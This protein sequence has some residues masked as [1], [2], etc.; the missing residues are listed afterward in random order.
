MELWVIFPGLMIR[1]ENKF[2]GRLLR[3]SNTYQNG[4][5]LKK[6]RHQKLKKN[7]NI[8]Q[9]TKFIKDK[10]CAAFHITFTFGFYEYPRNISIVLALYKYTKAILFVFQNNFLHKDII[11]MYNE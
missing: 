6:G 4:L 7:I 10:T 2:D 5:K 1:R 11:F 3:W 9:T 8:G